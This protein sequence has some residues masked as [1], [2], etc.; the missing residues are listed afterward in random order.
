MLFLPPNVGW[1]A[2][3]VAVLT[4]PAVSGWDPDHPL[5][6][7]VSLEDLRIERAVRLGAR[8]GEAGTAD[9][10]VV[11]GTTELPLLIA[12]EAPRKVIRAAFALE[13]SNFPL[14]PAF[15]IFLSNVLSWMMDEQSAVADRHTI[16]RVA[17]YY[18]V[19]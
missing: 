12:T 2:P 6:R 9:V 17:L 15:P 8:P 7:F 16:E 19:P 14:Q 4:S 3:T 5:M 1:L 10:D 11:I 13:D 18:R